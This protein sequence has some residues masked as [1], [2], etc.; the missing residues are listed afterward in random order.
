MGIC[1]FRLWHELLAK[2]RRQHGDVHQRLRQSFV[3]RLLSRP[4]ELARQDYLCAGALRLDFAGLDQQARQ[5]S[6][7][8]QGPRV[9]VESEKTLPGQGGS[10]WFG[11]WGK[12]CQG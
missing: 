5:L 2:S 11:Y 10:F 6:N 3:L 4:W 8:V 1:L 12:T 9:G 7:Q